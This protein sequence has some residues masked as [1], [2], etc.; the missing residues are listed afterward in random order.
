MNFSYHF[1]GSANFMPHG[2]FMPHGYCYLWKPELL[3]LHIISDSIVALSY[4]SIPGTLV[5]FVNKR[6][7]LPFDWIFLLFGAFIVLCG[8]T[9][10][11]EIWTLWHPDYWQAGLLK[12]VTALVSVGTAAALVPLVP[13]A[14]AL[15]SPAQLEAEIVERKKAE[16]YVRTLNVTLEERVKER[17]QELAIA[18]SELVTEIADR[19]RAQLKLQAYTTKLEQSNREL[20]DFAFVASHDLQEPLRKIQ[21]F[22]DRLKA[23]FAVQLGD[24]GRDFLERMQNAAGRMQVLIEDLLS[25]SRITSK[26][27]P[28]LPVD[29]SKILQGVLS[30]LETRIERT[31]GRMTVGE[32]PTIDADSS[33]MRQ[34]FQNLIGNALKF[35]REG[36]P[37]EIE[38]SAQII[39]DGYCEI[40]VADNGIGFEEKYLD[41]IFT[42]F[43]RLHTRSEYEGTGIGLAIC[44][45]IVER[46]N[47]TIIATS[48]LGKGS[49]FIVTLLISQ[50][51]GASLE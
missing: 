51:E 39:S 15:P 48:T 29:L 31:Q 34:L 38:V 20:Q 9:H 17:T 49:T 36:I 5:Y 30:D 44:R 27:Q 3:W 2:A 8:S 10:L 43:Q 28:F 13:K 47:G 24:Q 19:K 46:H 14:L 1:L 25:F 41:R 11:M 33:Q 32:L 16:E 6:K 22:G 7:D 23:K 12:A 4:Y 21:A 40:R 50:P 35:H 18:N 45:K 42:V 37:P 26:A